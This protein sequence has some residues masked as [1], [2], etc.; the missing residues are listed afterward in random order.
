MARL[1]IQADRQADAGARAADPRMSGM[2][3]TSARAAA[4]RKAAWPLAS[5]ALLAALLAILCWR[6]VAV[7]EDFVAAIGSPLELDY[8]EGIVWQQAAL[9]PGPRMYLPT[10]Q[11]P[12]IVFHYPPVYHLLV[13]AVSPLFS[14]P[15]AAGRFVSSLATLTICILVAAL[16]SVALRRRGMRLTPPDVAM[17]AAAGLMV[18]CLHVVHVWGPLMRV[19]STAIALSLA[20]LLVGARA[21][22]RPVGT[23]IGLLL[24]C[25]AVYTKHTQISAGV[26]LFAV[27]LI[28]NPRCAALSATLAGAVGLTVLCVLQYITHGGFLHNIVGHNINRLSLDHVGTAFW[29]ERSSML[30]MLLALCAVLQLAPATFPLVRR[31]SDRERLWSMWTARLDEPGRACTAML[32]LYWGVTTLTLSALLKSGGNFNYF[33]EWL[34][35][36]CALIGVWL[37]LLARRLGQAWLRVALV[38]L[39]LTANIMPLHINPHLADP[40]TLAR[41]ARIVAR[42]AAADKPVASENMTVLMQAGK[43]VIFEPAIVT[44]L[45]S[46]GRWDERPLIDMISKRQFAFMITMSGDPAARRTPAF[47]AAMRAAY[48]RVEQVAPQMWFHLPPS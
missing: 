32:V 29:L 45:A 11:L 37:P 33:Y 2:I 12:F 18:P 1:A 30:V 41:H 4:T 34:V 47:E 6:A 10:D 46:V 9:I 23:T 44:E 35:A 40:A 28:R 43:Q 42:I 5:L 16:V 36:G 21:N 7:G 19:D 27:T 17:V 31:S 3:E 8:G 15:L 48:P 22:A 25:A 38:L 26:A 13:R 14:S 39:L 20:G 24:C